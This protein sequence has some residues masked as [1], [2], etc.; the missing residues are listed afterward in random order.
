M[1]A[2]GGLS[3]N[4]FAK[5]CKRTT[6]IWMS[7]IQLIVF[8]VPEIVTEERFFIKLMLLIFHATMRCAQ[9]IDL[10]NTRNYYNI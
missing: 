2:L 1:I 7:L 8:L 3:G 5:C 10:L 9:R 4:R 6:L